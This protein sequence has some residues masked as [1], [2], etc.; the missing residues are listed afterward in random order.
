MKQ[1]WGILNEDTYNFDKIEFQI[2]V[3]IIAR[4]LTRFDRRGR[5]I[6]MQPGNREWVTVIE[7]INC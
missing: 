2:G 5:P 6:L 4:V 7:S 1:K 3:I